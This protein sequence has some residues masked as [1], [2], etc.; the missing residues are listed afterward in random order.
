MYI[1]ITTLLTNLTHVVY[2]TFAIASPPIITPDVGVIKF[3]RPLP[4]LYI[5]IT[6]SGLNPKLW[7]RGPNIGIDKLASHELEGIK[8]AKAI[9]NKN[10]ILTNSIGDYPVSAVDALL[11]TYM[12]KW[13][14]DIIN[15]TPLDIPIIRA[16]PTISD[17][18]SIIADTIC[19]SFNP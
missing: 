2:S 13:V 16:T 5:D 9:Y 3:T 18:P 19:F 4:A 8:N 6:I 10:A 1:H 14:A 17:A 15:D 11:N 12:S 7:A